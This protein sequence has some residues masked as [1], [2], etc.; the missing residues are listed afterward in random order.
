MFL[1]LCKNAWFIAYS[2]FKEEEKTKTISSKKE[3]KHEEKFVI[4]ESTTKICFVAQN[5]VCVKKNYLLSL[6]GNGHPLNEKRILK[7]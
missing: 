4:W 1:Q 5:C 7:K 2:K 6:Q 3:G